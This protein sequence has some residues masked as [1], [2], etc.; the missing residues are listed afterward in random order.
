[1]CATIAAMAVQITKTQIATAM[2][3]EISDIV[4]SFTFMI[5]LLITVVAVFRVVQPH[6][7]DHERRNSRAR[8]AL[9]ASHRR[10]TVAGR[11]VIPMDWV[12]ETGSASRYVCRPSQRSGEVVR[13]DQPIGTVGVSSGGRVEQRSTTSAGVDCVQ[14]QR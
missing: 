5:L 6:G 13:Q 10:S 14:T 2:A 1:M 9:S 7:G 11:T 3:A 12:S 8:P 4:S